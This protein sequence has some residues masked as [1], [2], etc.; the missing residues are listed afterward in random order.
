MSDLTFNDDEHAKVTSRAVWFGLTAVFTFVVGV[1]AER[2]DWTHFRAMLALL[3][4]MGL[5][6]SVC[7]PNRKGRK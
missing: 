7:L 5:L 1:Y 4:L 3:V 6:F 2:S